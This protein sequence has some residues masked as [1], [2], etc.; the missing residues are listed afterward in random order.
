MVFS[1]AKAPE[2]WKS[3]DNGWPP[4]VGDGDVDYDEEADVLDL[5]K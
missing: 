4:S 3:G 1:E 5:K 2:D